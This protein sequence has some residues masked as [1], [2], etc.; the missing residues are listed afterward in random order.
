MTARISILMYHQVG[1]F[2]PMRAHRANYCDHR[3]FA[4]QMAFLHHAGFQVL[5]LDRAL[6]CLRGE[7]PTPAR[8]VVLTFDD[9]YENFA[10][11]ALRPSQP[12]MA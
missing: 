8:A 7:R 11:Y 5:G 6:A 1:E 4:R 3:R 2:A 10:D 9:A 12:L